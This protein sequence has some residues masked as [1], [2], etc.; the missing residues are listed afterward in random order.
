MHRTK[1]PLLDDLVGDGQQRR[2]HGKA[3]RAG[4]R[5]VDDQLELRGLD[6]RQVRGLGTLEAVGWIVA[7]K[8]SKGSPAV[9]KAVL[10]TRDTS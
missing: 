1:T 2:R 4:G 10:S 7:W 5:G 3:E 8:P 6:N 9:L